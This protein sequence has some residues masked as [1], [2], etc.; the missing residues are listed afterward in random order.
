MKNSSAAS[1]RHNCRR[2]HY[3]GGDGGEAGRAI[4]RRFIWCASLSGRSRLSN[5]TNET[6]QSNQ[7]DQIPPL[8]AKCGF[9]RPCI[10]G[11]GRGGDTYLLGCPHPR[12]LHEL[13]RRVVDVARLATVGLVNIEQALADALLRGGREGHFI[14]HR[15]PV[16][17][18][19]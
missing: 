12:R 9:A 16:V 11:G 17:G 14:F 4:H 1:L 7:M 6:A 15:S 10:F 2:I 8:D 18:K 13:L 3:S 5:H 19:L